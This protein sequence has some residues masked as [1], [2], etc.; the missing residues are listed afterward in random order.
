[1]NVK[2]PLE[3]ITKYMLAHSETLSVAESVTSGNLQASLSLAD[4]AT[5]FYQGGITAY[6]LGQKSRHLTIDPIQADACNC[7]SEQVAV[8][9]AE[10]VC[11]LFS[12]HWGIGIT[13]YAASVP[14]LNIGKLFAY[15][16]FAHRG[17]KTVIRK[18]NAPDLEIREAQQYF[19]E[20]VLKEFSKH[21]WTSKR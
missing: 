7:V 12:S 19:V 2:R 18:V 10:H 9:M 1:M 3:R 13:G 8:E 21:L 14:E 17:R 16:A 4:N 15:Y 20:T 11:N 5:R 6:N